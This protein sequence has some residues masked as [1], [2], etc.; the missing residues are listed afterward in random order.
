M[1][2]L[3]ITVQ[4]LTVLHCTRWN[5]TS[6]EHGFGLLRAVHLRPCRYDRIQSLTVHEANS[7]NGKTRVVAEVGTPHSL[8]ERL[9]LGLSAYR[10][11]QPAV[12]ARSWIHAMRCQI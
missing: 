1:S 8:A 9:P 11:G 12:L 10:N 3:G 5:T 6:L 4:L 2:Q 7:Q